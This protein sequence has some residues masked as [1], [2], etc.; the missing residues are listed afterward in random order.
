MEGD[1]T[2]LGDD[3]R[4]RTLSAWEGEVVS[5]TSHASSC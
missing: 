2:A 5:A 4:S 1:P 3:T